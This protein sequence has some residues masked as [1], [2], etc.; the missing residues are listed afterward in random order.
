MLN[1]EGDVWVARLEDV[2]R[3]ARKMLLASGG[4][5][6]APYHI[7]DLLLIFMIN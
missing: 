1:W 4:I 5:H 7:S 2:N 3:G 6:G